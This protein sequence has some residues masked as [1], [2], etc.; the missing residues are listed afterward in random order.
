MIAD[1]AARLS[2]GDPI[3]TA[4][5][6]P[7]YRRDVSRV[8]ALAFHMISLVREIR[9]PIEVPLPIQLGQYRLRERGYKRPGMTPKLLGLALNLQHG[10]VELMRCKEACFQAG[11]TK[12]ERREH[13]HQASFNEDDELA[14][15]HAL[16][17]TACWGLRVCEVAKISYPGDVHDQQSGSADTKYSFDRKY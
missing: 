14:V 3:Q 12:T 6:K 15:A 10:P 13:I 17:S 1:Y 11:L 9:S 16:P 2:W 4:F 5:H 7:K 8:S